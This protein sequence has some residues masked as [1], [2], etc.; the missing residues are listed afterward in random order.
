MEKPRSNQSLKNKKCFGIFM[1]IGALTMFLLVGARFGKIMVGGEIEGQNLSENVSRLY[2]SSDQVI[3]E[4]GTIFDRNNNP[5]A[6]DA[7]SYKM[8]AILTD[9]W[10]PPDRPIHVQEPEEIANVLADHLALSYDEA[11]RKLTSDSSQVEFGAAG[12]NLSYDTVKSLKEDLKDNN[13]SGITFEESQTRLYPNGIFASHIIGL[14]QETEEDDDHQISGVMGLEAEF[15]D[16]LTGENG[17]IHFQKD[18][19][20]YALPNQKVHATESVDGADIHLT[21]D[22]R[23]QTYLENIMSQVEAEHSPKAM[24]ATVMDA[25]T[26]ELVASAQRPSFNAMT[27]EGLDQSWQNLLV[28]YEFE[29]GSTLKVITLAAAIEEGVFNPDEYYQ[30]GSYP[31]GGGRVR[32]VKPEGWGTI[33]YLE[34]LFR[35]SNVSFVKLVEDM[36]FETWKSYL[37]A[38]GF[39]SET[40]IELPNE[41]PGKNPFVWD[42][43]K[44]NTAFGQGITVTPIQMLQAMTAITNGGMMVQPRIVDNLVNE[45]QDQEA[46]NELTIQSQPIS[47]ETAEKTLK[48][49]SMGVESDIG[50]ARG[51]RIDGI[52]VAA[53]T[54]TAQIVNP[55]TGR[56]FTGTANHIFSV[57]SMFP[58]NDPQYIIYITVQ[59]PELTAE[60]FHG[61]I[62]VMNIYKPLVQRLMIHE[63]KQ[64]ED[65][66]IDTTTWDLMPQYAGEPLDQATQEISE[67]GAEF[68]VV[69][70]GDK[71][72]SQYPYQGAKITKGQRIIL[73]TNNAMTVPDFTG[74]SRNDL[75]KLGE[76]TG[77]AIEMN[78][79]GF[80]QSQSINPGTHIEAGDQ[81]KVTLSQPSEINQSQESVESEVPDHPDQIWEESTFHE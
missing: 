43:Q 1:F 37:D 24:T 46:Q 20:G 26:G 29:P 58:A 31:I 22:R 33:S 80:V 74:W 13:L 15:D 42:L 61:N 39:A 18:R 16:Q 66:E 57:V 76:M 12:N 81:L 50:T 21:L 2:Q 69:G 47:E 64:V 14:A 62:I 44:A 72:V 54:G 68:S 38:F 5:I 17:N 19:F 51:Y 63:G 67:M 4:R 56:Y 70:E 75:S 27:K 60:A 34:G 23:L 77:I 40:G 11:Y 7:T 45:D 25:K 3:A 30:S 52:P 53:K 71:V 55:E 32:D 65:N 49:L 6:V 36:G 48:Y 79:E 73:L 59:Q 9:S 35:S 41:R 78:G 10:S 28:D 8:I